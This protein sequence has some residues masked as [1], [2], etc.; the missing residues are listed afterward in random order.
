LNLFASSEKLKE[1]IRKWFQKSHLAE[2][3]ETGVYLF[4]YHFYLENNR[5]WKTSASQWFY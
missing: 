3:R 1:N 5:V 2:K 4:S